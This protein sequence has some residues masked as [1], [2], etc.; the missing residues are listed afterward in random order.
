LAIRREKD[1][2]ALFEKYR[3]RTWADVVGQD[4]AVRTV[5][6]LKDRGRLSGRAYWVSGQSGTGKTTI[7]RLI[8]SDIADPIFIEEWNAGDVT[9]ADLDRVFRSW[10]LC[11][12]GKGGR[13]Y[14]FNE[15]HGLRKDV[16]RRLLVMLEAIPSHVAVIFTTTVEGQER[17]EFGIDAAPLLSRCMVLALARRDLC[18]PFAAYLKSC[19]EREGLNGQPVAYYESVLKEARNNLREAFEIAEQRTCSGT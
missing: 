19:M 16:V 11:A 1:M 14:I 3:P 4:K 5:Q 7:A 6:A 2:A 17:F 15:A 12:W 13:V 10:S 8:A 18:K 9:T